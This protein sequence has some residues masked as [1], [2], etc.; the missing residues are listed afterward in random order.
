MMKMILSSQS[1]CKDNEDEMMKMILSRVRVSVKTMND[2][3]DI[4]QSQS[5]CKD[6]EDDEDD[7]EQSQSECK[8]NE[9]DEDDIEQS[10]SECKDNEDDEMMKMILSRVRVSV[11]TMKMMKW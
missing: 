1:E 7:I 5:E 2:E 4:E 10:Q 9:D 6:N 11:K 8:D 3:D